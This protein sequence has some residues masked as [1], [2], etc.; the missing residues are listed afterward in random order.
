MKQEKIKASTYIEY[1]K[2]YLQYQD[3]R[4]LSIEQEE[5]EKLINYLE[6]NIIG[7]EKNNDTY[8]LYCLMYMI[9][10]EENKLTQELYEN[11]LKLGENGNIDAIQLIARYYENGIIVNKDF[12]ESE[13][14]YQKGIDLD[15]SYCKNYLAYVYMIGKFGCK[16]YK[17]AVDLLKLNLD[18]VY[19]QY[20]LGMI[21]YYGRAGEVNFSKALEYFL[22]AASNGSSDSE[23]FLGCMYENGQGVEKNIFEAIKWYKASANNNNVRGAEALGEAYF[24]GNGVNVDYQQA[25]ELLKFAANKGMKKAQQLVG[26]IYEFGKGIAANKEVAFKY[27]LASAKQGYANAQYNVAYYYDMGLLGSRDYEK[28]RYWYKLSADQGNWRSQVNLGHAYYYGRG[29]EKNYVEAVKWYKIACDNDVT[30]AYYYL[31]LCCF[32]GRGVEKNYNEAFRLMKISADKGYD[33]AQSFVGYMYENGLGVEKDYNISFKWY[34]K[35]ANQ[36]YTNGQYNLANCYFNGRGVERNYFEAFRLFKLAADKKYALA[37]SF[38][39]YMYEYGLG[40]EK[41]YSEAVKWYKIA[42]D[43]NATSSFYYLGNCYFNGRGVEKNYF[44]SFRLFKIAAEKKYAPAQLFIGYMYEYGYGVD[45][46]PQEAVNW[47]KVACENGSAKAFYYLANCYFYGVGVEKN[48]QE[49]FNYYLI[50]KDKNIMEAYRKLGLLYLYGKGSKKIFLTAYDK[51]MNKFTKNILKEK[52]FDK[53]GLDG[54]EA[55]MAIESSEFVL[56]KDL[57]AME[58]INVV[59]FNIQKAIELFAY[60]LKYNDSEAQCY[61][62]RIYL[63]GIGVEMDH[64][65]AYQYLKSATDNGNL[66]APTMLAALNLIN[67]NIGDD[68]TG[69]EYLKKAAEAGNVD[70]MTSLGALYYTNSSM[71]SNQEEAIKWLEMAA[72]RDSSIAQGVLANIYLDLF[73][74]DDMYIDGEVNQKA[75]AYLEKSLDY[76]YKSAVNDNVTSQFALGNI[77]EDGEY[78]DQDHEMAI[79]WY[80]RAAKLGYQFAQYALAYMY[81]EGI[82][83]KQNYRKAKKYFTLAAKQGNA[84]AYHALGIMYEYGQGIIINYEEALKNYK[85]AANLGMTLAKAAYKDLIKKMT[86]EEESK[87]ADIP[88]DNDIFISW[89]HHNKK[90]KDQ[91]VTYLKNK[92][93][94]VWESDSSGSGLIDEQCKLGIKYSSIYLILLSKESINSKWVKSE[95]QEILTKEKD[96]PNLKELIRPIYIEDVT[97][98]ISEL[99]EDNPF[100]KISELSGNFGLNVE[101]ITIIV[102]EMLSK[103]CLEK[104]NLS[105]YK[106]AQ[107]F[108]MFMSED[109]K[110]DQ[111]GSII[112]TLVKYSDGYVERKLIDE[113]NNIYLDEEVLNNEKIFMIVAPGGTGKSLF[114]KNIIRKFNKLN[115]ESKNQFDY[116]FYYGFKDL[117]KYYEKE[118]N[119]NTSIDNFIFKSLLVEDTDYNR[120]LKSLYL[121]G[122]KV[123]LLLDAIDECETSKENIEI[124]SNKLKEYVNNNQNVK[125]IITSRNMYNSNNYLNSLNKYTL[126]KLSDEDIKGIIDRLFIEF[127]NKIFDKEENNMMKPNIDLFYQELENEMYS[128]IKSNPLL[129][130]N[131]TIIY[132]MKREI[133]KN[134]YEIIDSASKLILND[135]GKSNEFGLNCKDLMQYTN[136]LLGYISFCRFVGSNEKIEDL[137]YEYF[138]YKQIEI[139]NIKDKIDEYARYL[140][141]RSIIVNENLYHNMFRCYFSGKYLFELIY[142]KKSIPF[143]YYEYNLEG[144]EILEEY[145]KEFFNDESPWTEILS[146]LITRLDYEIYNLINKEFGEDN[147]NYKVVNETLQ[148]INTPKNQRIKIYETIMK[149]CNHK[150]FYSYNTIKKIMENL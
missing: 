64:P 21:N 65:K 73:E 79:Y 149:L 142:Q 122:K 44:E 8:P 148:I 112:N 130:V 51:Y 46:N 126:S 25:L 23:Y 139:D 108:N 16:D 146:S 6:N 107:E 88:H 99:A 145:N 19:A 131:L 45:E 135:I 1:I 47:Y 37:Q 53:M 22:L 35:A 136:K 90:E 28:A 11:I 113:D 40:I 18:D 116:F 137:I 43:N 30:S 144:K 56:K 72:D 10:T 133:P 97:K 83:T 128:D 117:V 7:Y 140:R 36:G 63:F 96:S 42:C 71:E 34:E 132:F 91:L 124:V 114:L 61:L 54:E 70:A 41:N 127:K 104:H 48:Y 32:Y 111:K 5:K 60:C 98:D 123:C 115:L 94:K 80:E 141:V 66:E 75:Y 110:D 3:N 134:E 27:Y 109:L 39:G 138:E 150:G 26:E 58:E 14:W 62:G 12:N 103:H 2:L 82:G 106:E 49:A 59:N 74:K 69:I 50:A 119:I 95:I 29:I 57:M 93:Y 55:E 102:E 68:E 143:K 89:N 33:Y 76:L 85:E 129:L 38:V 81:Y 31:G 78:V 120:R 92:G 67:N 101:E 77:Y 87:Y 100:R 9:N 52:Y 17:K 86:L 121:Q 105:L 15:D 20:N 84:N 4:K 24:Y 118:E 13:K 147:R 125:V